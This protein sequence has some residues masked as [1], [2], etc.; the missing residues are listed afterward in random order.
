[1]PNDDWDLRLWRPAVP[2]LE[3]RRST[4]PG[5]AEFPTSSAIAVFRCCPASGYTMRSTQ[6]YV[7]SSVHD[8][9]PAEAPVTSACASSKDIA[10]SYP[11]LNTLDQE[12]ITPC[13][14]GR[15]KW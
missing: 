12:V 9:N 15:A 10:R 8:S 1:M 14:F 13:A 7:A 4:T 2:S 6:S 5:S 3:A 11:C